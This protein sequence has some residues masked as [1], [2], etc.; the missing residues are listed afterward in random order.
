MLSPHSFREK[1]L[2]RATSRKKVISVHRLKRAHL[3]TS[4]FSERARNRPRKLNFINSLDFMSAFSL[5]KE[6]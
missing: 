2:I 6:R 4:G 3:P 5:I 1:I